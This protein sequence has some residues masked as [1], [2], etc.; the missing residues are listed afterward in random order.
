[1][2]QVV[3]SYKALIPAFLKT[4]KNMNKHS[5]FIFG[6][7]KFIHTSVMCLVKHISLEYSKTNSLFI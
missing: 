4:N 2:F 3:Y 6:K 1:M 5:C 7:I